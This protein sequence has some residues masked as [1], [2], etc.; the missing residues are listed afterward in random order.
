MMHFVK[1]PN[2][3][4]LQYK[5]ESVL[6]ELNQL[7]EFPEYDIDCFSQIWGSTCTGFDKTKEGMPRVGGSAMTK[8]YATVVHELTNDIYLVFFGDRLCYKVE[9]ATKEF[10]KDLKDRNLKPLSEALVKY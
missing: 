4:L 5:A 2:L 8:E 3:E 7:A 6:R 1:L 10:L 9:K